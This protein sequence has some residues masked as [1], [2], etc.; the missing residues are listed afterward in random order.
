MS[1]PR[2]HHFLPQFYLRGFSTDGRGLFQVEKP[3]ATY[4]GAQIKDLAAIRD[5]YELDHDGTTD[6]YALERHLA[7]LEREQARDVAQT[8]SD[9]FQDT[10][11]LA[12]LVQFLAVMRMRVPAVK[13]HIEGS[14]D[15][16]SA[17]PVWCLSGRAGSRRFRR[18]WRKH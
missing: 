8:L 18:G 13:A 3:G 15:S 10:G 11:L 14:Y 9:G 1:D 5:F 7:I 4:Y 2:K 16:T 6:R 12:R 17:Q